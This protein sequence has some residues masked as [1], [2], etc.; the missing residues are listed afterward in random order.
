MHNLLEGDYYD[1]SDVVSLEKETLK[2]GLCSKEV[3]MVDD[4]L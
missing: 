4:M 1:D 3:Q 2:T